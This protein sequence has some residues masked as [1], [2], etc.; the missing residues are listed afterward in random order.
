[1]SH[2]IYPG[3]TRDSVEQY[4]AAAASSSNA[5]RR[6]VRRLC[7][8]PHYLLT[9]LKFIGVG[10]E[11]LVDTNDFSALADYQ[12][13]LETVRNWSSV[14]CGSSYSVHTDY[15]IEHYEDVE[16]YRYKVQAWLFDAIKSFDIADKKVLE[17][18]YGMGTDHLALA[19]RGGVMH[20]IDLTPA[21]Y[22]ATQR[23]LDLYSYRSQLTIGDAE[24]LPYSDDYFDFVYSFGVIHHSPNTKQTVGEIHRVLRPGGRCYVVVYHKN[25]IFFWWS[26]FIVGYLLR[27]GWLRRSLQQQLSLIEYPNKNEGIVVRLHTRKQFHNLFSD[28]GVV[29]SYVRHLLP[30]DISLV[31]RFFRDPCSPTPILEKLAARFGWYIVVEAQK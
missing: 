3:D 15:G 7:R 20:G 29:N 21:S 13:K 12:Y 6:I 19:R 1:V 27:G 31:N 23:R 30:S 5:I 14:P 11:R 17:I 18:G 2:V 8:I 16:R 10:I 24:L 4:G 9:C 26:V 22:D 25:S 28:F